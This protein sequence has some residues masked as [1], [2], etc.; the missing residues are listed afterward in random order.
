MEESTV[1]RMAV[2]MDNMKKT[3]RKSKF[4]SSLPLTI[5]V[6]PS[7][8]TIILFRYLPMYGLILPFKNMSNFASGFFS[9]EWCGFDNFKFLINGSDVFIALR[10]TV[11]Y[12]LA[13]I[14]LH[15]IVGILI[16]LM[17]YELTS[18]WIK[19]YQTNIFLPYFISWVVGAFIVK[20]I[21]DGDYGVANRI[22]ALFGSDK[23]NWYSNPKYWPAIITIINT[24]KGMGYN[25]LLYY[26]A[27][28]GINPEYY[29]A[30][31]IDGASKL[32][33][34]FYISIPMIKKTVVVLFILNV[35]KI[36][37][38]DFGL[39]YNV[40]LNISLLRPT[41]DVLDTYVYRA[42]AQLGDV[43]M[44]SAA[45]FFQSV[46]GFMLVVGTNLIVKKFDEDSS[47]F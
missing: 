31:K 40:P 3:K 18:K 25:I 28:I 12:N 22:L 2:R 27:L 16:A 4:I 5:L 37:H 41:T 19:V 47:L 11:L 17:L 45:A 20:A 32:Q 38:C 6:L 9:S 35:G 7:V 46:V 14:L 44:S 33:Q 10:N 24:W 29:E 26:A 34:I 13:F 42:M 1:I 21:F 43:G 8:I 15:I 36:M 39:F 23:V 30:A